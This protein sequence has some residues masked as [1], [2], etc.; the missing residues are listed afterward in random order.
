ML[1][2]FNHT[3][4][5]LSSIWATATSF[6]VS[7]V[8]KSAATVPCPTSHTGAQITVLESATTPCPTLDTQSGINV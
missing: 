6:F 5:L 4:A 1:L 8:L 7:A 2:C 3:F